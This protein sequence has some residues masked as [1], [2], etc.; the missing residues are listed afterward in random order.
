M[1][2][3]FY[4]DFY[5]FVFDKGNDFDIGN[6]GFLFCKLECSKTSLKIISSLK[7]NPLVLSS[8]KMII[9]FIIKYNFC[10]LFFE[11]FLKFSMLITMKLSKKDNFLKFSYVSSTLNHFQVKQK[12]FVSS[13]HCQ[14]QLK[15]KLFCY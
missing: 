10:L 5:S 6:F 4:C 8:I 14:F 9:L 7:S 11:V 15:P 1:N 3:K 13:A 2:F 12:K